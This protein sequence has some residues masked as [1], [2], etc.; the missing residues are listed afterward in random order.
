MDRPL[1]NKYVHNSTGAGVTAYVI[2]SGIRTTHVDFG[3]RA[4][5][6][7][8]FISTSID[9]CVTLTNN[10]CLGH[11]THVAGTLGG[12]TYGVAKGVTI[13]SVKVCTASALYGCPN[14]TGIA[15]VNLVTKDYNVNP[16]IPAIANM[17]LG[18]SASYSLDAAV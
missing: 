7:A 12:T 4:S 5:I 18:G 15:G 11:G 10:D 6:A 3:G 16:S 2:D 1:D 8:D 14:E 13:R 9:T 17:S